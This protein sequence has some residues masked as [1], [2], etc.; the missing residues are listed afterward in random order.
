MYIFFDLFVCFCFVDPTRKSLKEFAIPTLNLPIRSVVSPP[1]QRSTLATHKREE[2]SP[3]QEEELLSLPPP[4]VYNSFGEF[5]NRIFCLKLGEHWSVYNSESLTVIT[6]S[7][8]LHVIPKFEFFVEPSLTFSARVYGWMLTDDNTVYTKYG[9][10]FVNITLSAFV[11]ELL[12]YDVCEGVGLPDES[13][14]L[15]LN[16]HVIPNKFSFDD[17]QKSEK[18]ERFSQFM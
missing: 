10:S 8:S 12:K 2:S 9:R 14:N 18:K 17:Y 16:K 13:S 5:Q 1:P 15:Y 3:L 11:K 7:S 4:I 6:C